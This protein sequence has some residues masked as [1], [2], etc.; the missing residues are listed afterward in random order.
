MKIALVIYM[1]VI[2]CKLLVKYSK[3][4][5]STSNPTRLLYNPQYFLAP[6]LLRY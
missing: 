4:I 1:Y 3:M 6:H 5:A 2:Y